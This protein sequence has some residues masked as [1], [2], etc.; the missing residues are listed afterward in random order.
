MNNIFAA[1]P[2]VE[3]LRFFKA[4]VNLPTETYH[5]TVG[6]QH[7]DA[8][9]VAG[10]NRQDM[11]DDFREAVNAAIEDGETIEQFRER[12]DEIVGKYGWDYNGGRNWRSRIIY[13]TNLY[14]SYQAGRYEQQKDLTDI[15]PYWRYVHNDSLH[16]RPVHQSWHGKVLRADDPW[17][18][19]HYPINA[20]NCHCTVEAL[21]DDDLQVEGW[22]LSE[23]PPIEYEI[24][25]I[26]VRSGNPKIVSVPVGLDYGFDHI[27]GQYNYGDKQ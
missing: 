5:D 15:L 11:I 22:T 14:S 4:K 26:G 27:P 17:W 18:N 16:P 7:N 25:T 12:F 6:Q 23:A 8:F 20:Y 24:K 1:L 3:Q 10:A 2:F 21:D 13:E 9:V 19:T